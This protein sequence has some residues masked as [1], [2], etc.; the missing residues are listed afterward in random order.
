M[1][2][3]RKLTAATLYADLAEL[4]PSADAQAERL[5]LFGI[6]GEHDSATECPLAAHL[7]SL[8]W[9]EPAVGTV[10]VQAF[11]TRDID[12]GSIVECDLPPAS[13]AFVACFGA[14]MYPFLEVAPSGLVDLDAVGRDTAGRRG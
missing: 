3:R 5:R 11:R 6:R 8:G 12:T 4:G 13:R 14:G 9:H 10:V 7:Q 2:E 1:S